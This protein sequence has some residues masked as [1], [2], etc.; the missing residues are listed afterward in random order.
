MEY[1]ID[2]ERNKH[3][4]NNRKDYYIVKNVKH[5]YRFEMIQLPPVIL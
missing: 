1:L 3:R 5:D 2:K 4:S